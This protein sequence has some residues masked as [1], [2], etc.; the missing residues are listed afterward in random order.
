MRKCILLHTL[1]TEPNLMSLSTWPSL[2]NYNLILCSNSYAQ[3]QL[4]SPSVDKALPS[5]LPV[6]YGSVK[7]F[8]KFTFSQ[9]SPLWLTLKIFLSQVT[10]FSFYF[11]LITHLLQRV[12]AW[13]IIQWKP[14]LSKY[15]HIIVFVCLF[16]LQDGFSF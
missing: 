16:S 1:W 11:L 8:S 10:V 6:I 4:V 3:I 15:I 2:N 12:L 13:P 5:G 14:K 9:L 7:E